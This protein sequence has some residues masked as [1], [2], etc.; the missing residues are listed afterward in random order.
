VAKI[1]KA[2]KELSACNENIGFPG[3]T[4]PSSL[5]LKSNVLVP[6]KDTSFPGS[7]QPMASA[8]VLSAPCSKEPV[9]PAPS[10]ILHGLRGVDV[11][12]SG[13]VSGSISMDES[14]STC[15]SLKSPQ[16]EYIDNEDASAVTLIE[17]KT[18][19]SLYISDN[20]EKTG[21]FFRKI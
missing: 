12:P 20:A 14:M 5:S 8:A 2:K 17:R 16:F 13:S 9:L 1:A 11:S 4:L 21:F 19:N 6:S 7:D 3:K 10:S 15:D 18:S